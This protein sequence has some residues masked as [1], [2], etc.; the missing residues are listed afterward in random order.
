M[1]GMTLCKKCRDALS[2]PIYCFFVSVSVMV[3][4]QH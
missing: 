3:F 1:D 2:L 4:V